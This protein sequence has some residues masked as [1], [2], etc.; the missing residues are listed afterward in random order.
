MSMQEFHQALSNV[1]AGSA[2]Y[3]RQLRAIAQ[4]ESRR[5]DAGALA[6]WFTWS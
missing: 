6:Y 2:A 3:W 5:L 1:D 4:T